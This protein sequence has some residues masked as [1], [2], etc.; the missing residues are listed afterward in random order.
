MSIDIKK[1]SEYA[2]NL[3][4]QISLS[5][6]IDFH[7]EVIEDVRKQLEDDVVLQR[8]ETYLSPKKV[9]ELLEVD[10]VTLWRW[11][12]KNYLVPIKVGGTSKYKMSDINKILQK[13]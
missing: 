3:I 1:L 4:I 11:E 6:L 7:K 12:K 9:S 5:D 13:K 8:T 2:P 10:L